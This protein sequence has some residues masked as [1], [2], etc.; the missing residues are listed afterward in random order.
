M[1]I[2]ELIDEYQAWNQSQGLD[3]GSADEHYY[4]ESLTEAQREWLRD[5]GRRWEQAARE[6]RTA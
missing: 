1:S 3:L 4:D 5:F 2:E 6:E